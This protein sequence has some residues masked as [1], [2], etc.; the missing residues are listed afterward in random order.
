MSN[1]F[2]AEEQAPTIKEVEQ[3][4]RKLKNNKAPG[5]DLITTV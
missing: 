1:K 3:A 4:I 2:E 5:V